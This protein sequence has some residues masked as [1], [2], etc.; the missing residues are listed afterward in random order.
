MVSIHLCIKFNNVRWN[1]VLY[2]FAAI[3]V[4]LYWHWLFTLIPKND[5]NI[6]DLGTLVGMIFDTT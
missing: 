1:Y 6:P 5:D 4:W 2:I 3:C